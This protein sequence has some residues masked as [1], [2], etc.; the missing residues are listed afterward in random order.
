MARSRIFVTGI[1]AEGRHGANEGEKDAPQGL[2]VDLDVELDVTGD[3]LAR[4]VD[5]RVL[6][7]TARATVEERSFDLLE[8][9]ADAVAVA[10]ASLPGVVHARAV[11][12]KPAA[13]RS[14]DVGGVAA[15]AEAAG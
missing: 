15:A 8:S 14:M 1:R 5:Y 7:E 10:V 12:H 2:V 9:L 3:D 4:T 11:V 6:T 13:A